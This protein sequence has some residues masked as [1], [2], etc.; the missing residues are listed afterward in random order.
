MQSANQPAGLSCGESYL[1]RE[2]DVGG[3]SGGSPSH[4]S[5]GAWPPSARSGASTRGTPH[6]R[7]RAAPPRRRAG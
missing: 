1:C 5:L 3:G 4:P 6:T 7:G 2:V